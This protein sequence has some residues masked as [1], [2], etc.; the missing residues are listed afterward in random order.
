MTD[1]FTLFQEGLWEVAVLL[2]I[3]GL[4]MILFV[5]GRRSCTSKRIRGDGPQALDPDA[6]IAHAPLF[7]RAKTYF[8]LFHTGYCDW[9]L[10]PNFPRG[11]I[12]C[13]CVYIVL[14]LY[15]DQVSLNPPPTLTVCACVIFSSFSPIR[16]ALK[17]ACPASGVCKRGAVE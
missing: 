8:L 16:Q 14:R 1:F 11:C 15:W 13:V 17:N 6:C 7:F 5:H 9:K 4:V 10:C 12:K 2:G 3:T